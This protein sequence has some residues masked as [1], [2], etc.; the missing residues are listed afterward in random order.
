MKYVIIFLLLIS[1]TSTYFLFQ[2]RKE[3]DLQI[4]KT[5]AVQ[6]VADSLQA[7]LY[8]C[9][10]ELNRFQVAYQIFLERNPKAAAQYGTIISE[11]TE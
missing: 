7:D 1:I 3:L 8:P 6:N 4:K 11:E 9:E 2:T 10:I 5:Q